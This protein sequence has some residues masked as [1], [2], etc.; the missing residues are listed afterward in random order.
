TIYDAGGRIIETIAGDGSAVRYEYDNSDRLIRTTSFVNKLVVSTYFGNPPTVATWP[1]SHSNDQITPSLY[2]GDGNLIGTLNAQNFVNQIF[3]DAAG[4]K[5][6]EIAYGNASTGLLDTD[7]F[8]TVIGSGHLSKDASKDISSH[9][10]Y[11]GQ[12]FLRFVVDALN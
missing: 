9:Y 10:V 3:Y 4:R 1:P 12:G 5:V 2:D 11:D 6:Q 8:D 7:P